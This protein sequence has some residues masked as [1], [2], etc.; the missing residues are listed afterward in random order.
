VSIQKPGPQTQAI[1]LQAKRSS[2][3]EHSAPI[4]MTSS[5]VFDSAEEARAL[6][7]GE[8]DNPIYSRYSNPN[9]DEF[10][11]KMC[12]LEGADTGI[13]T[14]SGMSAI[15]TTLAGLLN[16]GDHLVSARAVFGSSHQII[17]QILPRWGIQHTYVDMTKP[18][19]WEQAI[20]PKTKMLFLETPSNPGMDLADLEQ[21]GK[22]AKEKGLWLVVDNCFATPVLQKP[23]EMGAHVV[24]HSATKYI[25]GQ[26]RSLG[27][28][29]LGDKN[30]M[31]AV[32]FFAK[33]SGPC[34]SP[35]NSWLLS[36][37]LETLA[38]R[39]KQHGANALAL[40][41]VLEKNPAVSWV[42]YP[43]LPSHPQYTL[44]QKQMQGG[45][46]I[47][48]FELKGGLQAGRNFLDGL[49]IISRSANLGD[50][51]SI[52]THPASTTH[53]KLTEEERLTVG[54]T[55]GL[56]RISAGLEDL[57]DLIEDIEVALKF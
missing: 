31:E 33:H 1:R 52:A 53:S 15:F 38:L 39:V 7:A 3:K 5:F 29:I 16:Q 18:Q 8:G 49:S 51:R 4:Y 17:T 30:P 35:F 43:F 34:L 13:T 46:G 24:I 44:A 41:K 20:T 37:S 25:D 27:G 48:T 19:E 12:A 10:I 22:L 47:V 42:K 36:K 50:T 23:L 45:G 6:F 28:I 57:E 56:I 32:Y 2:Y 55:P 9:T 26:G 21:L 14:A 54:I 40:A 11:E